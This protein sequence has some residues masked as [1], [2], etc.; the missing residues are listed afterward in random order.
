[1]GSAQLHLRDRARRLDPMAVQ[2]RCRSALATFA[3]V[4]RSSHRAIRVLCAASLVAFAACHSPAPA[5]RDAS[6]DAIDA[7]VTS[8]AAP[9]VVPDACFEP[10]FGIPVPRTGLDN[11]QC[12]PLCSGCGDTDFAAATWDDASLAALRA[13]TE[14]AAPS[15]LSSDPYAGPPP[16]TISDTSVCAV[17]VDDHVAR[18]YHVQTF[19]TA[20]DAMAAGAI[21]THYGVCG[22]C[23]SLADLAV[24]ASVIDLADP[25]R[26]CGIQQSTHT[27][28]VACIQAIGF[29][30][31]CAD[32]WAYNTEHTRDV[33][34]VT[35]F[36]L[37]S[38]PYQNPDGT[39]NA[40]LQCDEDMS[41]PVFKAVAGRTRRNT[42]IANA[43]CRPC[44]EVR[45]IVH[46]YE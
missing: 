32:I 31:P 33:C 37:L 43:L 34:A 12:R 46:H 40:C 13:W 1:M 2:E 22:L 5:T 25:V 6:I 39:L 30:P 38:A 23:S 20:M 10:L 35:C 41:G 17:V 24:Y 42:G 44:S 7:D 8:E 21:V 18:T 11:T 9:D 19:T 27:G 45:R 3:R 26:R 36:R 29:T 16:P 28:L 15:T 4:T 14:L